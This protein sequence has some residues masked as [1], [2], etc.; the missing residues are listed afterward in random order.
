MSIYALSHPAVAILQDLAFNGGSTSIT[1]HRPES[2]IRA[3]VS[4]EQIDPQLEAVVVIGHTTNTLTMQA[5]DRANARHLAD[6]IEAIA[7]GTLETAASPPATRHVLLRCRKCQGAAIGFDYCAE[8]PGTHFLHGVKCRH[9]DCQEHLGFE[10]SGAAAEHWN[11]IQAASDEDHSGEA[12]DMVNHPP[13]YNGHPSGIECI[14]VTE[15]LPF[16]LGNAFK[17][18]F[19]HRAKNG[20]EDLLKAE[21]Y[22][23]R[24]LDRPDRDGLILEAPPS[25]AMPVFRIAAHESYPMGACLV[26]ISRRAPYEALHWL[27][28]LLD[29]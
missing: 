19:R 21:W 10:T 18:V 5:G 11:A 15:Q 4:I 7:N 12:T 23:R 6:F 1:L 25:T 17:Y 20:R 29:S 27:A 9:S 26:A 24:E 13:H 2:S 3:A 16:N 14:E 28:K 8:G 22:L